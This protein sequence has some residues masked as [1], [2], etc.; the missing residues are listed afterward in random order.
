MNHLA[1]RWLKFTLVGG[2]GIGVQ[3]AA[4]KLLLLA[5]ID[6]YLATPLAVELAVLH[7]FVWHER[8]TWKDRPGGRRDRLMRLLRF[9]LGNGLVSILGNELIMWVLLSRFHMTRPMIANFI[10]IAICSFLNFALS[11]W[12]VFRK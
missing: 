7:N 11:E 12:F 5:S 1:R 3:L 2:L 4:L 8:F 9:H 10:A 6:V